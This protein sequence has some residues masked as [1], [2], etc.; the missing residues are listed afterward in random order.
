MASVER[1]VS[2]DP[3]KC[4][5]WDM[6]DRMGEEV[7]PRACAALIDSIE[8]HGQKQP[9]LGRQLKA[10]S[11]HDVELIYGA[12]RLFVARHLNVGLLVRLCDI[13][14]RSAL[15]EMDIENRVRQDISS[16]ERGLSYR[17]WLQGG[18]FSSQAEMA[19][20][21]GISEAQVSRLLR[22]AE[23]PAVVVE[24]FG[25]PREIR[26]DWAVVLAKRC[27]DPRLREGVIQRARACKKATQALTAQEIFDTLV[28][29]QRK[30]PSRRSRD[31]VVKGA[32]GTPVLRVG[33]RAKTV[34]LIVP[35]KSLD[36]DDLE[37]LADSMK[38]KLEN[39]Q[40][41]SL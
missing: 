41:R 7:D 37:Q 38:E 18:Y 11:E 32:D 20:S 27:K 6:H 30:I 13:D 33:Y 9:V 39:L 12:R 26:E 29:S 1:L 4:R 16:Y 31:W 35:R 5:M 8:K 28:G 34:H 15:I 36:K 23:L 24:A 2:I 14:D 17:D 40:N 10:G 3:F 25:K 19:K 22:Y 21:I